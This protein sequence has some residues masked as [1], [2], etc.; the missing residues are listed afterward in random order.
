MT[1]K[2]F[3]TEVVAANYSDESHKRLLCFISRVTTVFGVLQELSGFF[4][5]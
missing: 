2:I 5:M 4:Y 1:G 3:A